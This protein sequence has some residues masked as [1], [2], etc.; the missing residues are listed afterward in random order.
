VK[1]ANM[2]GQK[3]I[4]GKLL[5]KNPILGRKCGKTK[6]ESKELIR[7]AYVLRASLT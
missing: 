2:N 7:I 4:E 3:K 6:T 1:F 5:R